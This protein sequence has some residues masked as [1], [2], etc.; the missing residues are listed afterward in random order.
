MTERERNEHRER[1]CAAQTEQER[2][3]LRREH[4]KQMQADTRERGVILP[5]ERGGQGYMV[6]AVPARVLALARVA[7]ADAVS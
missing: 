7:A 2:K 1:M 6:A 4:H 3:Q 5:D